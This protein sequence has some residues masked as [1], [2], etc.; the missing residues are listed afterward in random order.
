MSDDGHLRVETHLVD[1]IGGPH[2]IEWEWV[3]TD[4]L[5]IIG[6]ADADPG[7]VF[8]VTNLA[9]PDT[10]RDRF[11]QVLADHGRVSLDDLDQVVDGVLAVLAGG[12]R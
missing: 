2:V 7:I 3:G 8:R 5:T 12:T 9:T 10:L 6:D 1:L 11:R 4:G